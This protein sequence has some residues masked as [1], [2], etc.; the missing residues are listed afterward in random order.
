MDD[1]TM[2]E[3]ASVAP[4][5]QEDAL[6]RPLRGEPRPLTR[7]HPD[8]YLAEFAG[9]ALLVAAG[10]SIVIALWGHDAP[11]A[12][13]PLSPGARRLLNGFLF[14]SVGAA[15]A[16]SAIGRIS[17]AH[18]N[19]AMTLAFLLMDKM[20]LRD[21]S[22]YIV[23]QLLGGA[24]GAACLL[25]W[26]KMG[27]SDRWGASLPDTSLPLWVSVGGEALCTFLLVKLI[28]IF[29]ARK[30]T[31]PFTPLVNPPLF[32]LLTYL[33]APVS[34]ASANPA[35][36]FGPELVGWDWSGWWVYWLGPCL[37]A[38]C[39]VIV[40]KLEVLGRHYPQQARLFHFGHPGGVSARRPGPL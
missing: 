29:A 19:P 35:R 30:A 20:K 24:F 7:L 15:I 8:M 40:T 22:C 13:L 2:P 21:A 28:F 33:E 9:T 38:A 3:R 1:S 6:D 4:S 26:G 23:A 14:G 5:P 16:Y 18:I 34:G 12:S 27:A 17:G 39:A 31:Q 11:L 32:A 37:G 25:M 10:L 36:S